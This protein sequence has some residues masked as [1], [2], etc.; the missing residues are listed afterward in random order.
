MIFRVLALLVLAALVPGCG[1][2]TFAD[3]CKRSATAACKQG[4]RC[5]PTLYADLATCES[6]LVAKAN[7]AKFETVDCALDAPKASRCLSDMESAA[8]GTSALPASC[9]EITCGGK[10]N[11]RGQSSSSD[12][13]GCRVER[14]GC[15]DGATYAVSSSRGTASC[16]RNEV[17]EKTFVDSTFCSKSNSEQ[18]AALASQCGWNF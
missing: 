17:V 4:L 8:C 3:F 1:P 16:L 18:Q 9:T 5:N 6:D 13:N 14:S 10:L 2:T 11:C 12:T 7:C 15:S